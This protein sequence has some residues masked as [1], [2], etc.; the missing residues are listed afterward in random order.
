MYRDSLFIPSEFGCVNMATKRVT[1][2]AITV[3]SEIK[4]K[5]IK[6]KVKR[7]TVIKVKVKM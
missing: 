1:C 2:V 7:V 3:P 6:V 5:V 4:V